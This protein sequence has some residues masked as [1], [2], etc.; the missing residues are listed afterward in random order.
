MISYRAELMKIGVRPGE[1]AVSYR[2]FFLAPTSMR[3]A[4]RSMSSPD[5]M[6]EADPGEEWD[7]DWTEEVQGCA[8]AHGRWFFVSNASGGKRL[9]VMNGGGGLVGNWDL[10]NVPPPVP[11]LVGFTPHHFGSVLVH[12]N[13][14]YIDHWC[15]APAF[16]GQILVLEGADSEIRSVGW[17]PMENVM[18]RRV[19]MLAVDFARRLI[20][21]CHGERNI[22]QV[23]LLSLDTGAYTGRTLELSPAIDD[24]CYAQGGF[25][26]P[27]DH[28]F[29]SSGRGG[30]LDS[31][32]DHQ[33]I[34]CYSLLNGRRLYSVPVR[35]AEGR[36][37][38]QGCCYAPLTRNGQPV[39]FHAVLLENEPAA[40]DDVY[41]KSFAADR[42]ELI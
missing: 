12:E 42:P 11:P 4:I 21:A 9:R 39:Q 30:V 23:H 1:G 13:R 25:L 35:T 36:Q 24:G 41:L 40:R 15:D 14:V 16:G 18:G 2:G 22:G 37:E 19:G 34:Y 28:L 17:I 29:I 8:W 31:S 20:V 32:R 7:S 10:G 5:R 6:W 33:F 3:R 38:L 27:N 26:S